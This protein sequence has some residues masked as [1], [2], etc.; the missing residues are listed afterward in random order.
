MEFGLLARILSCHKSEV[1]E[2][3]PIPF[4]YYSRAVSGTG[5]HFPVTQFSNDYRN[6]AGFTHNTAGRW[7]T[8][9]S[10][11]HSKPCPLMRVSPVAKAY[12][13]APQCLIAPVRQEAFVNLDGFSASGLR[14][15]G[16][17]RCADSV[18]F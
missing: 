1:L 10:I 8:R 13:T 5:G 18:L 6:S 9:D 2:Q 11:A 14:S 4:R 15:G 12:Y 7:F 17:V 16:I 3:L